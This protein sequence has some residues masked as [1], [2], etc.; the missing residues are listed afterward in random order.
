M[1]VAGYQ[2]GNVITDWKGVDT[3]WRIHQVVR[4]YRT[5]EG[6]RVAA[7]ILVKRTQRGDRFAGAYAL[8]DGLLVR[9]ETIDH[10]PV[11]EDRDYRTWMRLR[12]EAAQQAIVE[13]DYWS[14]ADAEA[15]A[16]QQEE[17]D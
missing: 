16:E 2:K 7:V 5:P 10:K 6:D 14:R 17:M 8:G 15:D 12:D 11:D 4:Q 1:K 13:A 3:H 9:G